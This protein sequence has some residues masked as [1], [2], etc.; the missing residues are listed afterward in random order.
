MVTPQQR[1]RFKMKALGAENARLKK[2]YVETQI[3]IDLLT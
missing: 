3:K 2:M 1:R